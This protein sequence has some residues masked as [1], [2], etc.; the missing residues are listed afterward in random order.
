V[1]F[2]VFAV[3]IVLVLTLGGL[4][5]AG[6]L[7]LEREPGFVSPYL[8]GTLFTSL[9]LL[10][11]LIPW[12]PPEKIT[13]GSQPPVT[14]YV[15]EATSNWT[16]ILRTG[17]RI[18]IVNSEDVTQ[19]AVCMVVAGTPLPNATLAAAIA[20]LFGVPPPPPLPTCPLE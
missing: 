2:C 10:G 16:T 11:A 12:L 17:G 14:G 19:R 8:L 9:I 13:L 15:L 6:L 5:A 20:G 18:E 4:A 3:P 7:V 1:L